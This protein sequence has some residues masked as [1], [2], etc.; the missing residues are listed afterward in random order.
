MAEFKKVLNKADLPAGSGKA[1]EIDGKL[2]AVFNV[3]GAI[4]AIDNTC[5]HRGGPLAEGEV[6]G[7]EVT[8]PWHRA[9]FDVRTGEVI[10]PP[11]QRAV[12]RYGVRVTG[13]DIEVEV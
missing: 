13:T 12:V 10:G 8:C 9:K 3:D 5:T 11:A 7:H 2:I 1:V 6:S 4:H